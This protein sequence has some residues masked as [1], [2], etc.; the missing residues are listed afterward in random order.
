MVCRYEG[1]FYGGFVDGLGMYTSPS[2]G[3]VYKGEFVLG[4]KHG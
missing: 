1:E 3:E 2:A 4:K